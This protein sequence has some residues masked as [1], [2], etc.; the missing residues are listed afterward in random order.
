MINSDDSV[1]IN[2]TTGEE[3]GERS[4]FLF[5]FLNIQVMESFTPDITFVSGCP[6][7]IGKLSSRHFTVRNLD[8]R[9]SAAVRLTRATA[10]I[11][12]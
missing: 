7:V 9:E 4:R 6:V 10:H 8:R 3:G 5:F 2:C 11:S 1:I 12:C